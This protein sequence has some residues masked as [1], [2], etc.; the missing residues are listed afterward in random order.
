[1]WPASQIRGP[2]PPHLDRS[3]GVAAGAPRRA[4]RSSLSTARPLLGADRALE[5]GLVHLRTALDVHLFGLVVELV[6]RRAACATAAGAQPAPA[7]G[8]NVSGRRAGARTRF[9]TTRPFLVD[10]AGGDLLCAGHRR[11]LAAGALLD[12]LVLP[13]ALRSLFH[14]SWRHLSL[15]CS[16]PVAFP[17]GC[18][19]NPGGAATISPTRKRTGR[20]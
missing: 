20:D 17:V 1:M 8:G 14:S 3:T 18:A 2:A 16:T 19:T 6:A 10:G 12:V 13:S 7:T 5:L 11:A 9:A 4:G 15:L